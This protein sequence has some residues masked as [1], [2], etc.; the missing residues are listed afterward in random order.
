[1]IGDYFLWL[2]AAGCVIFL[3]VLGFV[4]VE[5]SIRGRRD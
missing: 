3:A 4:T 5:E 1:M 2:A